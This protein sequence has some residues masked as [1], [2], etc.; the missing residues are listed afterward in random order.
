MTTS[1]NSAHGRIY[2]SNLRCANLHLGWNHE[3]Y[4]QLTTAETVPIGKISLLAA[5]ATDLRQIFRIPPSWVIRAGVRTTFCKFAEGPSQY[6]TRSPL[7]SAACA[8]W[9]TLSCARA[10]LF[11]STSLDIQTFTIQTV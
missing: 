9:R 4:W 6:A 3:R 8:N 10:D 5:Q 1:T 2:G 7:P 11:W